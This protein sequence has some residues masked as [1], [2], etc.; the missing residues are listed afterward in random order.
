M[1]KL[2]A[3]KMVRLRQKLHLAVA[4]EVLVQNETSSDFE[5]EQEE[6][7]DGSRP[8]LLVRIK[9]VLKRP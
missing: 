5:I 2:C 8:R 1:E 9:R 6:N 7:C 3:G 4:E